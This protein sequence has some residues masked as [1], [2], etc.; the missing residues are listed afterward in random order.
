MFPV[1]GCL[2][3]IGCLHLDTKS[4]I[5]FADVVHTPFYQ[6]DE[7]R[8]VRLSVSF[9]AM[10]GSDGIKNLIGMAAFQVVLFTFMP[11]R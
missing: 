3:N 11:R 9:A 7:D 2:V 8:T 4:A 10:L 6:E 1:T 5:V